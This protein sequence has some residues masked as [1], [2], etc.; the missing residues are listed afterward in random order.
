MNKLY[1]LVSNPLYFAGVIL[2]IVVAITAQ[3]YYS[4]SKTFIDKDLAYTHYN[5]YLIFKQSFYHLIHNKDLY[6]LYPLEHFDY[7]KY[8]PSFALLMAPIA[9]LPDLMGL[10]IWNLLNAMVLMFALIKLPIW[11][12]KFNYLL[13]VFVIIELITS[14]Q[15]SQSNCLIAGLLIFAFIY[16]EKKN[17]ALA[18]LCIVLTVFIK[19]FGIVALALFIFYPHKLKSALYTIGWFIILGLLPLFVCT[20]QEL[21]AQYKSWFY[22]LSNDHSTS[23]GYSVAGW[24]KTWF[25]VNVKDTI[26]IIGVILFLAPLLKY[27]YYDQLQF[28]LLFLASILI[29]VVIFNH[30]AESPTFIIAVSG[31]IIWFSCQERSRENLILLILAFVFTTLSSTD[32]F[33]RSIR[34][35][36]MYPYVVKVVPSILIWLKII[37]EMIIYKKKVSII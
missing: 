22:L 24:L 16:L 34:T 31:I 20:S 23:I 11:N 33:P 2:I 19:L 28:R 17:V 36:Y 5:N 37:V 26:T 21:I 3:N 8:S 12:N 32:L 10:F 6:Q 25:N 13:L 30:K 1:K 35:Q 27:K 4:G 18:S 14:L 15:N 29:W 7:Y 9:S